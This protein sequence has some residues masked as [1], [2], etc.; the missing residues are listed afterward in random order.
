[1]MIIIII[2]NETVTAAEMKKIT[3]K[4]NWKEKV[5]YVCMYVCM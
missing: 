2:E 3:V 1:M 5:L 4:S